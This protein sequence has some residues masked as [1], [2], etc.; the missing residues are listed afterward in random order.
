MKPYAQFLI[1]ALLTA[2]IA[3]AFSQTPTGM[4]AFGSGFLTP[5]DLAKM[6]PQN[7]AAKAGSATTSDTPVPTE[8]QKAKMDQMIA[9]QNAL[10]AKAPNSQAMAKPL[11]AMPAPTPNPNT[12][13]PTSTTQVVA[14][15][16]FQRYIQETDANNARIDYYENI[17]AQKNNEYAKKYGTK[18]T[19]PAPAAG[20]PSQTK[21]LEPTLTKL[22]EMG[23]D[24]AK[25]DLE[26]NRLT[27]AQF[28]RW[29]TEIQ[30]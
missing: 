16:E 7:P 11:T 26:L 18:T 22:R 2:A 5:D 25:I 14:K 15:Q 27:P 4:P 17:G 30:N 28:V 13:A 9:A 3:P 29:A 10:N 23:V 6:G 21:I 8:A 19:P 20:N 1:A 12:Q 24:Q